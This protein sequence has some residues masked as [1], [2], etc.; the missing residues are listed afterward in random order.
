MPSPSLDSSLVRILIDN[1]DLRRPVGAGFLVTPKHILTCAHVVNTALGRNLN[2]ADQP[3]PASEVFFDFPLLNSHCLLWAKILHWFPVADEPAT[4]ATGTTGTLE[5][6][7][8][9]ELLPETPLPAEA[10]P[11]PLVALDST[12][13]FAE[14]RLRMCGF[15]GSVDQG[16]YIDGMLKGRTGAG[17]WEIHPL[18]KTRPI[19]Q[20]FSGTAVWAVKENAVCGMISSRLK[21]TP[22]QENG[23]VITGYML[24]A[25]ALIRAFPELDQHSRPANPYRGLEAFREKDANLYFGR[26]KTITRLKQVV[27]ERPFA[28]VIGASGSGKSSVVFAGLLPALRKSGD[29]LIAHCRPKKQPLYELSA[30]LIPLLYDDPI[31]RSEK[32]DEL[33]EKLHAGSVGLVGIIRQIREQ[34]ENLHLLLIIDQFEEL[35][36]LNTDQELIQQYIG[37]LLECLGTEHFTVLL[38]MRADFFAAAVSSPALAEA[39]DNS[40]PIILP[41]IDE[42]GLREVVEQPANVLG[43]YF[44]PGLTDLIVSDVGKEPGSLPLLEFCLTQLWERQEFRQISHEAYKAI[45]GVQQ[46]LAN[47]A[48]AVYAEFTE[49]EREQLRHIF[50]KLVRPGQGTED[51]RQVANL[52]QIR[53]ED[54]ALITHLADKRLIVTGRDEERGEETVEVVHEALIRR[55]QIL[56]QWVDEEREFLVWQEKLRVLLRQWEESGKDEGALL[57]GLPLDEALR[58]C[59]SHAEYFGKEELGFV[60]ASEKARKKE[61]RKKGIAVAFGILLAATMMVIFFVLWKSAE[62][63]KVVA[64]LKTYEAMK[65]KYEAE[66]QTLE[67]NYNLA[68]TFEEKALTELKKA[69]K[70]RSN[71]SYQRAILFTSSALNQKISTDKS[72]LQINST[73]ILLAP[74]VFK[75]AVAELF[76][77]KK[78]QQNANSFTLFGPDVNSVTFSPDGRIIASTSHDKT[79]RLWER[80]SGKELTILNG[81]KSWV[82]SVAFSP[83]GK[84]LASASNDKTVRLWNRANGKE[85]AVLRGHE[86][87]VTSV[88]FSPDG[89]TLASA[90]NDKT[91]RLWDRASGKELV[92]L[93]GHRAYVK[94]VAFCP[95]GTALASASWDGT[96]R[97]WDKNSGKKI[98]ILRRTEKEYFT[99]VAFSSDGKTLASASREG[100]IRLWDKKSGKELAVLSKYK[101]WISSVVFSPDGKTIASASGDNNIRLWDRNNGKEVAVLKG[102]QGNVNSIAFSPNGKILASVSH[103]ETV[104]LWDGKSGKDLSILKGHKNAVNSVAFSPD[105]KILASASWDNTVQLWDRSSGKKLV[106]LRCKKSVDSVTFSPDGKIIASACYNAVQLWDR[107]SYK[108]MAVLRGHEDINSVAFSPDGKTIVSASGLIHGYSSKQDNTVSIWDRASGKELALLK[109]HEE[110]VTSVVFSPDGKTIASSSEDNTIRLWDRDNGNNLAILKGNKEYFNSVTFSPDGKTIASASGAFLPDKQRSVIRLWDR[111]KR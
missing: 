49:Q 55:W 64:E 68:K 79:I 20:G 12:A 103:D 84:I 35:F 93:R 9:L 16:T 18:D 32:T 11:A 82:N 8:V 48:E 75:V 105:G 50:L 104:R 51:T 74:Q 98:A 54:R 58:W 88:A 66:Q 41:Q 65:E 57:R 37:I 52:E 96:I 24:P 90:S 56:R 42:Q 6:I 7:A 77:F 59:G 44:E 15:P 101:G 80:N 102:H 108:E 30:C 27:A 36:T 85:L 60:G 86:H 38:T 39:L 13:S 99:S 100:I 1:Q 40:A 61:R 53:A 33:K 110:A 87:I 34:H 21:R 29:W 17:S 5:D 62:T 28:A 92:V 14:H 81:H 70:N 31:L 107:K 4:D 73:G 69:E 3:S 106:T 10:Q 83:D 43:V 23:P 76:V 97:L 25:S 89:K 19:E 63:L 46:A 91:V 72:A 109:G 95:E 2:A 67:A 22:D 47:H 26:D 78:H 45:G 71:E 111:G 94:A